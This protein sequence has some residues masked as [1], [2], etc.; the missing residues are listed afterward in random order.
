MARYIY[1]TTGT[2]AIKY[3]QGDPHT[4]RELVSTIPCLHFLFPNLVFID[5]PFFFTPSPIH[6]SRPG[7]PI[8][9]GTP[10]L[11]KLATATE[12]FKS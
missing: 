12:S 4:S 2:E 11:D 6:L 9:L 7:C 3:E 8:T 1:I 5:P 10:D